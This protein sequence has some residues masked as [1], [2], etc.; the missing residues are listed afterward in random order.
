MT[1]YGGRD[2]VDHV[3]I[4]IAAIL[5]VHNLTTFLLRQLL[6]SISSPVCSTCLEGVSVKGEMEY[7]RAA[8]QSFLSN[9][10]KSD[11]AS[12]ESSLALTTYI[13]LPNFYTFPF[14]TV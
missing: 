7:E 14:L 13:V 1:E 8:R 5:H 10:G 11:R 12:S 3:V 9:A 4:D 2:A 6:G